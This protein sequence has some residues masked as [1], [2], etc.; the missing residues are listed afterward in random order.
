[1]KF[2][3]M[4][5][6]LE[7]LLKNLKDKDTFAEVELEPVWE[8]ATEAMKFEEEIKGRA[9]KIGYDMGYREGWYDRNRCDSFYHKDGYCRCKPCGCCLGRY[10]LCV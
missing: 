9:Y 8:T 4:K 1:M 10:R 5:G 6:Q 7:S 3:V 2:K